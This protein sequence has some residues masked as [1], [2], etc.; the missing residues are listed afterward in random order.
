MQESLVFLILGV[1][2]L[3]E[4]QLIYVETRE[5]LLADL[6]ELFSKV[7]SSDRADSNAV[8][9]GSRRASPNVFLSHITWWLLLAPQVIS[10]PDLERCSSD[11]VFFIHFNSS[12]CGDNIEARKE[13][14]SVLLARSFQ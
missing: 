10:F 4:D 12:Y 1:G 6:I 11:F 8:S 9:T 7:I 13:M 2:R 3:R 5:N 14:C